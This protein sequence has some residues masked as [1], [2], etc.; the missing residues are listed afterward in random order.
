MNLRTFIF[1]MGL[2]FQVE[3]KWT[4][5]SETLAL[6]N[7]SQEI[8]VDQAEVIENG[9]IVV[10]HCRRYRSTVHHLANLDPIDQ[11][12]LLLGK[13]HGDSH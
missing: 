5:V 3:V 8:I 12:E 9:S 10:D 4:C 6:H 2:S 1:S 7:T 11:H 13:M